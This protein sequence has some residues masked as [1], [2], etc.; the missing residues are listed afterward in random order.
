[1]NTCG[2]DQTAKDTCATATAAAS[3]A[4]KGTGE[5][6]D[7]FNA[8]FGITTNFVAVTAID[9]QGN[10]VAGTGAGTGAGAGGDGA[11]SSAT[12]SATTPVET[13]SN[14]AGGGGAAGAGGAGEFGS[15]TVPQIE[16]GVGFDNRKETSFQPA[17][18]GA[19]P[20]PPMCFVIC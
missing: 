14:N 16:F 17:D 20:F 4:K 19:L 11:G 8:A 7:A 10:A 3:A 1:M 13:G 5:Q 15:C 2:A 9:N 12:D 18:L 6:A